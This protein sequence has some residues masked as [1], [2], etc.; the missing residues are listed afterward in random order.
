MLINFRPDIIKCF[1]S[2]LFFF[3][4]PS[5]PLPPP[6]LSLFF[7]SFLFLNLGMYLSKVVITSLVKPPK[8]GSQVLGCV[9]FSSG[10]YNKV[11]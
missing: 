3:S 6:F 9:L 11:P 2:F 1:S 10:C 7:P 5:L 8:I 4:L